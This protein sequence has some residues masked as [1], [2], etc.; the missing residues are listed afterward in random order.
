MVLIRYTSVIPAYAGRYPEIEAK[1]TE[2][3]GFR[4]AP[5]RRPIIGDD[6]AKEALKVHPVDALKPVLKGFLSLSS[7]SSVVGLVLVAF[8]PGRCGTQKHVGRTGAAV[9]RTGGAECQHIIAAA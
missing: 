6:I 1:I 8:C 5:E 7:L 3:V 9:V 4:L 2:P